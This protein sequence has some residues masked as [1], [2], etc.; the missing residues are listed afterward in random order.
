MKPAYWTYNADTFC[1]DCAAESGMD[2]EGAKDSEGNE[3]MPAYFPECDYRPACGACGH[4]FPA[5]G[6]RQF[7]DVHMHIRGVPNFEAR[8]FRDVAVAKEWCVRQNI[9][10]ALARQI[11]VD[12][13]EL[14]QLTTRLQCLQENIAAL[15]EVQ[16]D[17]D[18][19]VL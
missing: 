15:H 8:Q 18:D 5:N 19:I 4:V 12:I 13:A 16:L 3:P 1:N 7:V 2:V 17:L 6:G 10:E 14:M 9:R 11:Q